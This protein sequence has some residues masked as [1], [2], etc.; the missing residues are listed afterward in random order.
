MKRWRCSPCLWR[1]S[2]RKSP[3]SQNSCGPPALCHSKANVSI[4]QPLASWNDLPCYIIVLISGTKRKNSLKKCLHCVISCTISK[5]LPVLTITWGSLPRRVE[6]LMRLS[7]GI[8]NPGFDHLVGH[9]LLLLYDAKAPHSQKSKEFKG[10]GHYPTNI[11]VRLF[12]YHNKIYY[13][14]NYLIFLLFL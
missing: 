7:S 8:A 12:L 10:L 6:R 11:P 13:L 1:T 14:Y 3:V 4:R 9:S 5:A 2:R